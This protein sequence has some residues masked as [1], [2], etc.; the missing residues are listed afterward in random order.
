M[1]AD[2]S[3][4]IDSAAIRRAEAQR[5]R[6]E[7]SVDRTAKA[8]AHRYGVEWVSLSPDARDRWRD[9]VSQLLSYI[10]STGFRATV[11]AVSDPQRKVGE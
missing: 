2:L 9:Q 5:S 6:E 10:D 8:L 3:A 1:H 4:A 11:A 7:L